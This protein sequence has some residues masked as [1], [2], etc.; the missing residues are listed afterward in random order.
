M[1]MITSRSQIFPL[2]SFSLHSSPPPQHLPLGSQKMMDSSS[3]EI[4][5]PRANTFGQH[6]KGVLR[7]QAPC[8]LSKLIAQPWA[9]C[10]LKKEI[11]VFEYIPSL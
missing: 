8:P 1:V 6:F 2:L 4:M 7:G 3:K 9:R 5:W 11:S 10:A